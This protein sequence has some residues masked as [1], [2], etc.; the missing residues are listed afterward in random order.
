MTTITNYRVAMR[1]LAKHEAFLCL[2]DTV[3]PRLK[4]GLDIN[5]TTYFAVSC[6]IKNFIG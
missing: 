3:L 6:F 1:A 5:E 4:Q 2:P